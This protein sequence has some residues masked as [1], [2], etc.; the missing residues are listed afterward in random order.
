M[1]FI[2]DALKKSEAERQR[3]SGPTLLEL[4]ITQPRRRYPAWALWVAVLL[5]LNAAVLLYALLRRPATSGPA[6]AAAAIAPPTGTLSAVAPL[7]AASATRTPAPAAPAAAATPAAVPPLTSVAPLAPSAPAPAASDAAVAASSNPADDAPAVPASSASGAASAAA[8]TD[9]ASLPSL[10]S[11][12]G[13][14]PSLQLNLL[15]YS[16]VANERFALINMHRVHDGD[17]LPE[18]PRVLAITREG[19]ALDYHGQ[20]FM[21][22]SSGTAAP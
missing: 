5:A 16:S 14:L 18:G 12:G 8:S 22:R 20:Q 10:A 7:A 4:R 9:Y 3:Q 1:S 11:L 21:L 19:V 13:D 6:S 17:V 2:L 15:D